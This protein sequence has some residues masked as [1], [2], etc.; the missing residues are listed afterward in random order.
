[1]ISRTNTHTFIENESYLSQERIMQI[2]NSAVT[3]AKP[4]PLAVVEP[5]KVPDEL[6][7]HVPV[8]APDRFV[9]P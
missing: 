9:H 3:A 8:A 2:A 6:A 7:A 4:L 1:M 5:P